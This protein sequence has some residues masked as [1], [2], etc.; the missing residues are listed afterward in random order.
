MIGGGRGANRKICTC[1]E[2]RVGNIILIYGHN[3]KT[4]YHDELIYLNNTFE[5]YEIFYGGKEQEAIKIKE[6]K[7][8][9]NKPMFHMF[10]I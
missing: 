3:F 4:W 10:T 6:K 8:K 5:I 7:Y 9:I 2:G 1:I